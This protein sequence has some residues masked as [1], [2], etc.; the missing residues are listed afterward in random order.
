LGSNHGEPGEHPRDTAVVPEV[1]VG[2]QALLIQR[3]GLFVF[4]EQRARYVGGSLESS[5][6]RKWV[7]VR[8]V[9]HCFIQPPAPLGRL[10]LKVDSNPAKTKGQL[11]IGHE[12]PCDCGPQIVELGPQPNE[13]GL[14]LVARFLS[15][16]LAK[17]QKMLG[18]PPT[19]HVGLARFQ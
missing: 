3:A 17:P 11:G 5:R 16:G 14:P 9:R 15:H 7:P 13:R 2:L 1:T 8:P 19:D 10:R 4:V 12:R 18:V 6:P